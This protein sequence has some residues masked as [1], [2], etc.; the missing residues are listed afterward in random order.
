MFASW[1]GEWKPSMHARS[2]K[3]SRLQKT[4][5][6]SWPYQHWHTCVCAKRIAK[7]FQFVTVGGDVRLMPV[8][9]QQL[10]SKC[11]PYKV[12]KRLA[13]TDYFLS[14]N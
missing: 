6:F 2:G 14:I 5:K 13:L 10:I 12:P 4:K 1:V 3:R 7:G 9:A 8:G 11:D